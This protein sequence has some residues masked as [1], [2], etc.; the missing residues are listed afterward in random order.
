MSRY[1]DRPE[2]VEELAQT[3]KNKGTYQQSSSVQELENPAEVLQVVPPFT[4]VFGG[5]ASLPLEAARTQPVSSPVLLCPWLSSS[6]SL[7]D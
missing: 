7:A 3:R 5:T 2:L 4:A 1:I 6:F